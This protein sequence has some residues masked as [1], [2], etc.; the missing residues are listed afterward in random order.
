MR[1]MPRGW[2]I[3]FAQIFKPAMSLMVVLLPDTI[4]EEAIFRRLPRPAMWVLMCL[5]TLGAI[6][7]GD[8]FFHYGRIF[9]PKALV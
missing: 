9:H 2:A 8:D 3:P 6:F 1:T 7:L 5:G 4:F